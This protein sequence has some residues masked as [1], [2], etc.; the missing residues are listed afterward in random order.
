MQVVI[1]EPGFTGIYQLNTRQSVHF[2]QCNSPNFV[3]LEVTDADQ[4]ACL[5]RELQPSVIVHAAANASASWC[6]ANPEQADLLNRQATAF[7][8]DVG[9]RVGSK[10][11]LISSFAALDPTTVYARTKEGSEEIARSASD[12]VVLRPSLVLGMSP[13]QKNDRP[14]NRLLR[15]IEGVTEPRYDTSWKFQPTYAGHVSE[16]ILDIIARDIKGETIPIAVPGLKSRYDI[17]RDIL[18]SFGIDPIAED[19]NDQSP[20]TT[21]SLKKL[22]ELGLKE[23][24]YEEMT[25]LIIGEIKNRES[26]NFK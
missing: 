11:M 13:N 7:V 12:Y 10:F 20:V 23:Y 8:A 21:D 6:E 24:E 1:W 16:V 14:H 25:R 2:I 3:R 15:N 4:V 9:E 17:A 19:K 22:K 5:I 18:P 26:F